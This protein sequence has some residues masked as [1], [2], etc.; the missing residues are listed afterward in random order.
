LKESKSGEREAES[1]KWDDGGTPIRGTEQAHP[2][3]AAD[4]PD[5]LRFRDEPRGEKT[6]SAKVAAAR[7]TEINGLGAKQPD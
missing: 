4:V 7:S 2:K 1:S 6:R 3:V 5:E